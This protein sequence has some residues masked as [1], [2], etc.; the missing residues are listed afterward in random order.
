MKTIQATT[1]TPSEASVISLVAHITKIDT[2][3][4][5]FDVTPHSYFV[6]DIE[7]ESIVDFPTALKL[8]S[9]GIDWYIVEDYLST[10]DFQVF[11]N[12]LIQITE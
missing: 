3:F 6:Y 9:E 1:L 12:V 5:L 11:Q 7:Q 8:L 10:E 4:Y 2:W